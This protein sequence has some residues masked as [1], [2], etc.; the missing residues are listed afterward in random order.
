MFGCADVC[1]SRQLTDRCY[2]P[3]NI[4]NTPINI[5]FDFTLSCISLGQCLLDMS[6]F[7]QLITMPMLPPYGEAYGTT[8]G[9]YSLV[10]MTI[11]QYAHKLCKYVHHKC[12]QR[13]HWETWCNILMLSTLQFYNS[14]NKALGFYG[15]FQMVPQCQSL[16]KLPLIF[17]NDLKA[18][19]LGLIDSK[20][21][22]GRE[23]R[24]KIR[25]STLDKTPWKC[26]SMEMSE[27]SSAPRDALMMSM[28]YKGRGVIYD[29]YGYTWSFQLP[30]PVL[31][32]NWEKDASHM[33]GTQKNGLSGRSAIITM[34]YPN[35]GR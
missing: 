26:L 11:S 10:N 16:R 32:S 15:C 28:M 2:V 31:L 22:R 20:M 4:A 35:I 18:P 6:H 3:P 21:P 13:S 1:H 5:N 30:T 29:E 24:L 27:G 14:M 12:S 34:L 23:Q 9:R 25:H 8:H 17:P 33:H 19:M 7:S